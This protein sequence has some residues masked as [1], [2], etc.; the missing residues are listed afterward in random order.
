MMV[1]PMADPSGARQR[2]SAID[3]RERPSPVHNIIP[4]VPRI[5]PY[6]ERTPVMQLAVSD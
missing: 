4:C 3:P 2:K 6:G 1:L 5:L